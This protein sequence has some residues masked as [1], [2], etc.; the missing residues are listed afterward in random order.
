M[1]PMR[2]IIDTLNRL[3]GPIIALGTIGAVLSGFVGYWNTYKTM[4]DDVVPVVA[5][6]TATERALAA[7]PSDAGP[8]SIIVLP[9]ASVNV[10]A[11]QIVADGLTASISADLSRIGGIYIASPQSALAYRDKPIT[12]RQIGAEMGVRFVL[13]GSVQ[14]AAGKIRIN[15]QLSDATADAQ[16]WS[17]TFDGETGDLFALQDKVT[18]LIGN[19]MGR[20]LIIRAARDSERRKDDDAITDLVI[21]ARALSLKPQTLQNW[22]Q[23]EDLWRRVLAKDPG[24]IEAN[25]ELAAC[26]WTEVYNFFGSLDQPTRANKIAETE[27]LVAKVRT[28]DP[29]YPLLLYIEQ[30]ILDIQGNAAQASAQAERYLELNPKDPLAYNQVG[31]YALFQMDGRKSKDILLQGL[32]LNPKHPNGAILIN[33]SRAALML[34]EWDGA[35]TW[36][37]KAREI[38]P[39]TGYAL[40]SLAIAYVLKGMKAEARA[41]VDQ[42]KADPKFSISKELERTNTL[43]TSQAFRDWFRDKMVPAMG[44]AGFPE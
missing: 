16:I 5:K 4:R 27:I 31:I 21:R 37:Q 1:R 25:A 3:K 30:K 36:A 43:I 32:A 14:S 40:Q 8:L 13:R 20:E 38:N 39:N 33:L 44:L 11:A 2:A 23:V 12:A 15:A 26:L 9:F 35:V 29:G 17:E 18:T 6:S 10:E 34:G 42:A 7:L 19:S 28:I 41:I 22:L 24:H